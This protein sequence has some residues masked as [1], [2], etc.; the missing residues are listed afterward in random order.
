MGLIADECPRFNRVTRC[1]L[2]ERSGFVGGLV[3]G[4][5]FALPLSSVRC[6]CGECGHEFQSRLAA[7]DRAVSPEVAARLD[8]DALLALTNPDLWQA[9]TLSRLRADPRL[10]DAFLL[11]DRLATGPL[12]FGLRADLARWQALGEPD[13]TDLLGRVVA[14]AQAEAFARSMAGRHRVGAAGRLAG[15]VLAVGVWVAAGFT[16][17]RLGVG[18]VGWVLV[19]VAGL[20]AAGLPDWLL[21]QARGRNWVRD[22]LLPEADRAG[23]LPEWVLA[24]LEGTAAPRGDEDELS[25]IRDIGPALR[26][27]LVAGGR[28][29]DGGVARFGPPHRRS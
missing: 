7:E 25:G 19:V 29:P 14:C 21:S 5:P 10:R 16:C 24:V 27:E 11:L 9:R 8:T 2:T 1:L 12:C 20:A 17:V 4:I 28:D 22:V 6:I 18:A 26:A 23:A 3:F 15:V 13:R